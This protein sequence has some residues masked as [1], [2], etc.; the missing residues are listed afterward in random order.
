MEYMTTLIEDNYNCKP[1]IESDVI[2]I[3]NNLKDS[4]SADTNN[5]IL[6]NKAGR[7]AQLSHR[8]T[9]CFE[10]QRSGFTRVQFPVK[11]KL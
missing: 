11:V 6:K 2:E 4:K 9:S 1:I 3:I 10:P 5:I 8:E 7:M